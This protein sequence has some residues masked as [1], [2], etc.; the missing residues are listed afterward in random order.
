ME[1][2]ISDTEINEGEL[3]EIEALTTIGNKNVPT[4]ISLIAAIPGTYT[5]LAS[6]AYLYFTDEN[7]YWAEC[8]SVIV[9]AR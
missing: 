1:T 9:S 8:R 3:L 2:R 5:G 6:W 4:P 7:S